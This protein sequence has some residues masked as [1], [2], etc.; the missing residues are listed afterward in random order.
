MKLYDYFRSSAAYRVRIALNLKGLAPERAFVHLRRGAQRDDD[1]LALNPQGLVPSLV[2]DDGDVLTQSLAIVEW[3]DETHP[4]PPLLPADAAGRARVRAA[5]AGDRLRHPSAQQPARA[6][7][8]DGHAG[9]RPKRRRTAGTGTGATSGW[10]RSRPSSRATRRPARSVTARSRRSPTS[11]SCRSSPTRDASIST[12]RRIRRCCASRRRASRCRRSP[13]RR[14]RN[15]RT[16]SERTV[17]SRGSGFSRTGQTA[18][19]RPHERFLPPA[20]IAKGTQPMT[21]VFPAWDI[22][23]V[24]VEG[25]ADRFPV[26]H[27]YCVGRNYAEHAKEMGGDAT[28]EPPFFFT[29]PADAVVPVVPPAVGRVHYPLATK[30]YHHEIELVVGDR[31]ARREARAR[32][33]A[34]DRL[35][36]RG[37]PRHDAA[38]PAERHAREEAAV[39]H[40]QVVRGGRADRAAASGERRRTSGPGAGSG[41]TSTARDGSRATSPT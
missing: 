9:R 22:P 30:N 10:R 35:G 4:Q 19:R 17:P 36:L 15:S 12:S 33:R 5:R 41:S 24:P 39:G 16:P 8:P 23:A 11:A 20:P 40:R 29:K 14:R 18:P 2:T 13:P 21:T 25:S 3:L 27:I 37:R 6:E 31:R 7:L 38:R 32:R 34:R 28:K 26:R 1:Y